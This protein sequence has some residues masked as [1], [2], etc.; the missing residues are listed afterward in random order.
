MTSFQVLKRQALA[1][2]NNIS[3]HCAVSTMRC[4]V[5]ASKTIW[6]SWSIIR[7]AMRN[8]YTVF[9]IFVTIAAV[10]HSSML[11]KKYQGWVCQLYSSNNL[12]VMLGDAAFV[13]FTLLPA[14]VAG[15]LMST[16]AKCLAGYDWVC[17][18][19]QISVILSY[20]SNRRSIRWTRVPAMSLL[21]LRQC[22]HRTNV[23]VSFF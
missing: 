5:C 17:F 13:V 23:S 8:L 4:N 14:Y 15:Q 18:I 12:A 10:D 2:D 6:C 16:E 20:I 1:T 22:V 21:H 7:E 11:D 9:K 3:H 19:L